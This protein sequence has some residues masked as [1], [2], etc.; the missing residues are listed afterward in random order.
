MWTLGEHCI[1]EGKIFCAAAV[2]L[3]KRKC[4]VIMVASS[5]YTLIFLSEKMV[6]CT[7]TNIVLEGEENSV[8]GNTASLC[9]PPSL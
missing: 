8:Q 5:Q 1:N 2:A 6:M 7:L 3:L 9:L 4:K